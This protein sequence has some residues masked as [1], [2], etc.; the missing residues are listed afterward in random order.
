MGYETGLVQ[1][2]V[3]PDLLCQLCGLVLED[4]VQ[5]REFILWRSKQ[6]PL[7]PRRRRRRS[8]ITANIF[9]L[10]NWIAT[11]SWRPG[12]STDHKPKVIAT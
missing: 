7:S 10:R 11:R 1:G 6:R 3:G 2:E 8:P 4:G 9:L 12:D 5:V